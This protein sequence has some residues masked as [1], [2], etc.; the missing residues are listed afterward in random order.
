MDKLI[1]A[2]PD[3][4]E[5]LQA[6]VRAQARHYEAQ[7][8]ERERVVAQRDDTIERLRE[9]SADLSAPES[10]RLRASRLLNVLEDPESGAW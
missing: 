10:L 7:L 1:D 3:D 5:Q 8:A 6:V 9:L 4:V 2:L